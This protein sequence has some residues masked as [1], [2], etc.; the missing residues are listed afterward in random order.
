MQAS[1]DKVMA[2]VFWDAQG[3]IILDFL[4]KKSTITGAYYENLLD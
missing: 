3:I 4:A 1:A 2:I